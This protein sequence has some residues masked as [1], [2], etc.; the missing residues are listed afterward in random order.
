MDGAV[1]P[2]MLMSKLSEES[3]IAKITVLSGGQVETVA[4]GRMGLFD[5]AAYVPP[6]V[7]SIAP[8]KAVSSIIKRE[9][10]ESAIE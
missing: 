2:R 8:K 1:T 10:K 5:E 4:E 9:A 7:C 6:D 3:I